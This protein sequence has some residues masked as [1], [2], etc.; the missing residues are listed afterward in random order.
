MKFKPLVYEWS[1]AEL[2]KIEGG[3]SG[4]AG[5]TDLGV[6]QNT[7][8]RFLDRHSMTRR[9]VSTI[10]RI[11]AEQLYREDYWIPLNIAQ[12]RPDFGFTLFIQAVNLP[13]GEAVRILQGVMMRHGAYRGAIDGEVGPATMQAT[14]AMAEGTVVGVLDGYAADYAADDSE[15]YRGLITR[16]LQ[17]IAEAVGRLPVEGE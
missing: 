14:F 11:E 7:F 12:L 15:N 13:W 2:L 4:D 5:G 9:S 17:M 16:R 10:T 6:T 8:N 1:F 3:K